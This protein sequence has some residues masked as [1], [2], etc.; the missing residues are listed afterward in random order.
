MQVLKCGKRE[1]AEDEQRDE[2]SKRWEGRAGMTSERA[3]QLRRPCARGDAEEDHRR[4]RLAAIES[5]KGSRNRDRK[6]AKQEGAKLED[7]N[8]RLNK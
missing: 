8:T 7:G 6:S 2:N 4:W 1:A 3:A 5:S